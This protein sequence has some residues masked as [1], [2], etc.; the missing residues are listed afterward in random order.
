MITDPNWT[1]SP[2]SLITIIKFTFEL[3]TEFCD[4]VKKTDQIFIF[5]LLLTCTRESQQKGNY[6]NFNPD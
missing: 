3:I 1:Q 2:L 4:Q 5:L 6:I